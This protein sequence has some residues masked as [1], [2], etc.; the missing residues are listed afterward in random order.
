MPSRTTVESVPR[1]VLPLASVR[2]FGSAPQWRGRHVEWVEHSESRRD[3]GWWQLVGL[4]DQ[5]GSSAPLDPACPIA[6]PWLSVRYATI[7]EL[8]RWEWG[9]ESNEW[10][11]AVER[12]T[13]SQLHD[14]GRRIGWRS[15]RKLAK[16]LVL[17]RWCG[18][19]TK[20]WSPLLHPARIEISGGGPGQR[21]LR[22]EV[23]IDGRLLPWTLSISHSERGALVAISEDAEF[24]VGVDLVE[25]PACGN[26]FLNL[27]FTD[28][29]QQWIYQSG[30]RR[31]T[32][33][34]WAIKE[35]AYKA[36]NRGEPFAP[37]AIEVQPGPPDGVLQAVVGCGPSSVRV[38]YVGMTPRQEIAVVA[39]C[40]NANP[41]KTWGG[42][43]D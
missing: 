22:P 20:R 9:G 5:R 31:L 1:G 19:R 21:R 38:P 10:L 16:Q 18:G 29:E 24:S 23:S 42:S 25:P 36:T 2:P 17:E 13:Q 11:S 3:L 35:A 37:R 40:D 4:D 43:D 34:L 32:A 26:G 30:D 12:R 8:G 28:A 15:G 39:V 41:T 27:W 6:P 33:V 14:N 7:E